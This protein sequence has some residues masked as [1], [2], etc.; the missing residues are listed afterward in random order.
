M[1]LFLILLGGYIVSLIGLSWYVNR[2]NSTEDFLIAGRNRPAWQ[3]MFSKYAATIGAGWMIVYVSFAYEYGAG[4]G[5]VFV[6]SVV[7]SVLYALWAA[8]RIYVLAKKHACYT[9]GDFVYAVTSSE[10]SKRLTEILS[11]AMCVVVMIVSAV[12]GAS[13]MEAYNIFSYEVSVAITV[14]VVWLYILLSGYK[15]VM[16]T[17]VL[18]S[19][20]LLGLLSFLVVAMYS[21]YSIDLATWSAARNT[22]W[23]GLLVLCVFGFVT[24]FAD[25]NRYQVGFAAKSRQSLTRGMLHTIAPLLYTAFVL[26]SIGV[27][28]YSINPTLA[29]A[30]V[31]PEAI[32]TFAPESLVPFGLLMFFVAVM[33][34]M[35]S[36][37]Y[38]IATHTENLFQKR[39]TKRGT[40]KL[41]TG[42]SILIAFAAL[43][44]RDIVDLSVVSAA[45]IFTL[46]IPMMY[47][48]YTG[49][50]GKYFVGMTV[51][52][53][54]GMFTGIAVFGLIPD[55]GAFVLVGNLLG[56]LGAKIWFAKR[57]AV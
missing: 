53:I 27:L 15:A 22:S 41:I 25:P 32:F 19:I 29:G 2:K 33:S 7:G 38:V 56:L 30:A 55:A 18:Q 45:I 28:V 35:D 42:I 31:F 9:M 48:L 21:E 46:A 13:L 50:P 1:Q 23:L 5:I 43:L 39:V 54:V 36:F 14:G 6:G 37:M 40:Q 26:Y 17:D 51:G 49:G 8:P 4:I 47:L 10:W 20:L 11:I 44:W 12:G 24:I 34:S 57:V 52:G 16:L 3:V